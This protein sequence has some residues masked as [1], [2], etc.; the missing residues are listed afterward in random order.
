[1]DNFL[2]KIRDITLIIGIYLFFIAW[3][4]VHFYYTQFGLSASQL[5]LDYTDYLV[6]SYPV[7]TSPKFI[8][9]MVGLIAAFMLWKFLIKSYEKLNSFSL[10]IFIVLMIA[11][12]PV[13][14]TIAR[15]KAVDDYWDNRKHT[16]QFK[17]IQF[18]FKK[19][20]Y[21]LSPDVIL[22]SATF[23]RKD[24]QNDVASL[25]N[26]SDTILHL[27]GQSDSY[28]Y[29]LKQPYATGSTIQRGCVYFVKKEDVLFAKIIL[30]SN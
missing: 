13:F 6:Y 12:F 8:V 17:T 30:H 19:D 16:D 25:K 23:T 14:F 22:D 20:I 1:M 21:L 3:V 4:Y 24:F 5:K 27:L 26:N 9:C 11:V 7:V 28:Y 18:L 2:S 15:D 10:A 29:V